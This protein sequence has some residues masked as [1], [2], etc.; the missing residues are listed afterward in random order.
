MLLTFVNKL[1]EDWD[2]ETLFQVGSTYTSRREIDIDEDTCHVGI[3]VNKVYI[4]EHR[5]V[6][7]I[8]AYGKFR[9]WISEEHFYIKVSEV[10]DFC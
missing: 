9:S 7:V 4:T 2:Y 6:L 8:Q 1:S 3:K 5:S 10:F